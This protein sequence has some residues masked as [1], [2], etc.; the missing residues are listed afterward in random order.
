MKQIFSTLILLFLVSISQ[1]QNFDHVDNRVR[2]YPSRYSNA[3]QLALQIEA[4]FNKE[5]DKV[6]AIFTW[7]SINVAY[8]LET[9]YNGQ[10]QINFTYTS[11]EDLKRKLEAINTNTINS[12][13]RN[14][15]AICEGYAQ[16]FKRVSELLNIPCMLIGGYSKG[17]VSEIGNIPPQENHAWNAVKINKKWHLIDAT[18]GA[19]VSVGQRWEHRFNDFFFLTDPKK[20]ALTHY[21]SEKAWF[22]TDNKITL[23]A[24]YKTPIFENAY[25]SNQLEL[26]S[27]KQ[28]LLFSRPNGTVKFQMARLPAN[29][30]LFYAFTNNKYTQ[31]IQIFCAEGECSF[32]IPINSV[33]DT[34]LLIFANRAMAMQFRVKIVE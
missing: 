28:G 1:A 17:D 23:E 11:Q 10:T 9:L 3:E 21:P 5:I 27:P 34:E 29:T 15:R 33:S 19:G 32:E 26:L 18:W 20:F 22:L 24:F 7:L 4:D 14:K 12:T 31:E 13:L 16:T 30:S 25:F 2:E 8:D 6:R